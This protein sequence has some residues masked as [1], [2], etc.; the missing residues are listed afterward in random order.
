M[1][2]P[3]RCPDCDEGTFHGNGRCSRCNG[4][5]SNAS[6]SADEPKCPACHGTGVCATCGGAGI[7]PPPEDRYKVQTLFN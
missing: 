6:L 3:A 7:Y 1:A 5:G 4:T 2:H